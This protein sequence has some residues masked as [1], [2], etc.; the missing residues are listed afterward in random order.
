[1]KGRDRGREESVCILER[2]SDRHIER[3]SVEAAA[4]S[5]GKKE[6]ARTRVR[7]RTSAREP[8]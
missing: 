8:A 2:E 5:R 6:T 3:A 4:P 7:E 1:M